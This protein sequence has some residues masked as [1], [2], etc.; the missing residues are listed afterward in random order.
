MVFKSTL[1]PVQYPKVDVPAFI[2]QSIEN[3]AAWRD[4]QRPAYVDSNTGEVVTIG[5]FVTHVQ[6]LASGWQ[7]TVGLR[8]GD[9]VAIVSPNT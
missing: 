2:F 5:D 8:R 3:S 1:P 9:V 4:P 6:E 7:N